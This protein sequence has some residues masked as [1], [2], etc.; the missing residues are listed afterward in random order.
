MPLSILLKESLPIRR[1]DGKIFY[2]VWLC[3]LIIKVIIKKAKPNMELSYDDLL[4]FQFF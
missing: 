2:L 3:S 4:P 1:Q